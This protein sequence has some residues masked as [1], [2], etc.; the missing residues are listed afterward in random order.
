MAGETVLAKLAVLI[1]ANA[2]QFIAGTNQVKGQLTALQSSLQSANKYLAGFGIGFSAIAIVQGLRSVI[3]VSAEFE[4]TMSEVKAIT[5]ATGKEFESLRKN[6][7]DLGASTKFSAKEVGSLQIA[8]GRL[9]F[10]TSEILESTEAVLALAAATGEDLAKAADTAG[11]TV[12]GFGLAATETQRVVDVMAKS[13]NTTALGLDNFT[14][15]MKYVAPIAAAA[16]V[17]VEETTALLGVLADAGIRGSSAGTALR[18]IFGDLSKDGRPVTQ[19]LDEL[20][21]KGL[22]LSGAF[23]EV[24]RTAQTALLVLS[25]NREKADELSTS[26]QNVTGEAE[27]MARVMQD[28][29]TGDVEKLSSAWEGLILRLSK[30][31][32]IRGV[33]QDLTGLLNALSG[34]GNDAGDLM[35]QLVRSI[36]SGSDEAR[37]GFIDL[38]KDVRYEAGKPFDLRFVDELSEKYDLTSG[39][40]EILR[41]SIEAVN[42]E[43]GFQESSIK[44]FNTF[45]EKNG[46]KDLKE[47]ADAYIKSLNEQIIAETNQQQ[48]FK[49]LN[50][51]TESDLFDKQAAAAQKAID[52]RL[53]VIDVIKNYVKA[54][55]G[56]VTANNALGASE[57]EVAKKT[58]KSKEQRELVIGSLDFYRDV[59]KK[60]NDEFN[61]TNSSDLGSLRALS[62][63]IEATELLITRLQKIRDLGANEL[64]LK[65]PDTK[66]LLT[67]LEISGPVDRFKA[68]M[69]EVSD[70]SKN[71][72]EDIKSTFDGIDLSGLLS[73]TLAGIGEAFGEA[74]AGTGSLG[75]LLLGVLGGILKQ[76][77]GMLVTVG[78]G[79]IAAKKA[80]QSL[81]GY[82]A[83]A[84]GVALIALGSYFSSATKNLGSS[85]GS[86][87][88]GGSSGNVGV[89][90]IVRNQ[91]FGDEI[92]FS[93]TMEVKG[94]RLVAVENNETNRKSRLG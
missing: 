51:D 5:G 44:S 19:R 86:G 28:N 78:A 17:S 35:K 68:K 6:A 85:M 62:A 39:Q 53:Q 77:G 66:G 12:R 43:L 24:G 59:L 92:K 3:G 81:N 64:V 73:S 22:S 74:I 2:A 70:A 83:I 40:A 46:Y 18:K 54:S 26:F 90:K 93:A 87:G 94:N 79:I 55:E 21:K 30:T 63:R 61:N 8:L 56:A 11:S 34:Q 38:L 29:L 72:A 20:G 23:D 31:D 37:E 48:K 15:S 82:V 69:K 80:F 84:A 88:G 76:F 1:S 67:A 49:Q 7:I 52:Y 27:A 42:K 41:Q 60:L 13:F 16:N 32:A 25:K 33:T 75:K 71:S 9:G 57:D 89:E 47:A 58:K 65:A 36:Q 10:S 4:R 14:E 91:P 50:T 45:A